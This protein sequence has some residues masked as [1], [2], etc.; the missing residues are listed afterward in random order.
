MDF[1]K[2]MEAKRQQKG[3]WFTDRTFNLQ[4][5]GDDDDKVEF[6][7]KQQ[8]FVDELVGKTR[9]EARKT[10]EKAFKEELEKKYGANIDDI[11]KANEELKAQLEAK[12]KADQTDMERMQDSFAKL[13]KKLESL[14][15]EN[16]TLKKDL[17]QKDVRETKLRKLA[18]AELPASLLN[19]V[20]GDTEEE[21]EADIKALKEI[22][23]ERKP[24]AIGNPSNPGSKDKKEAER[25]A[26]QRKKA[27][28]KAK[29]RQTRPQTTEGTKDP[30]ARNS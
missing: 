4:I 20:L 24:P 5:F 10:A 28:E 23:G 14:S 2:A 12:N 17:E 29:E 26:E 1:R 9:I 22:F 8:A 27:A 25:I 6:D 21:I 18:E 11:I 30:W 3:N 7:E 19:R 16:A 15:G 13:E